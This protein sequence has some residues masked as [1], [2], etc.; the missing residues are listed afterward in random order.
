MATP[1]VWQLY[2]PARQHKRCYSSPAG[3][4][5]HSVPLTLGNGLDPELGAGFNDHADSAG[6]GR[7]H[8]VF[9]DFMAPAGSAVCQQGPVSA[10]PGTFS[11][12]AAPIVLLLRTSLF[13]CSAGSGS[14]GQT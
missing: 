2:C 9:A 11:P 13:S 6:A 10:A 7:S 4:H 12:W 1:R 5:R 8:S 14:A 3:I